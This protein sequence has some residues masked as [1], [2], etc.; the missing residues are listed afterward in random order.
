L[1]DPRLV[2]EDLKTTYTPKLNPAGG[3]ANVSYRITNAGNVRL[4]GTTRASVGGPF[5][6]LKKSTRTTG[7]NEILPGESVDITESVTN[8]PA[9]MLAFTKVDVTPT[10][11]Q[12]GAGVELKPAARSGLSLAIPVT[13]LA[14][15]LVAVFLR[16][17]RRSHRRRNPRVAFEQ[18]A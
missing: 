15:A 11:V 5:G 18:A 14:L 10:E 4:A 16:F 2:V 17:A 1:L 9:T 7:L 12:G 13:I 3:T 8:V 6:L